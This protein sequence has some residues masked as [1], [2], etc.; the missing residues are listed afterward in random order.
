MVHF[1]S[2]AN[3]TPGTRTTL[4]GISEA[5]GKWLVLTPLIATVTCK[6]CV[7]TLVA[8]RRDNERHQST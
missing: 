3:A 5:T 6:R 8:I 1:C 7:A 4:C 2:S